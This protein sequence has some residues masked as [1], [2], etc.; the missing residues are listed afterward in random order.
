MREEFC[1]E[2]SQNCKKNPNVC[3]DKVQKWKP[4]KMY[5][6]E[7]CGLLNACTVITNDRV[8]L[9]FVILEIKAK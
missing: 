9:C 8:N 3:V 6:Y 5:F 2:C 4:P 1:P 7:Y